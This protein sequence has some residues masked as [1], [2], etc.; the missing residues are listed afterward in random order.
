MLVRTKYAK[1]RLSSGSH[2]KCEGKYRAQRPFSYIQKDKRGNLRNCS[3]LRQFSPI[4]NGRRMHISSPSLTLDKK[5][6]NI[7]GIV[8]HFWEYVSKVRTACPC[9]WPYK[10]Q[11][12]SWVEL[13][14]QKSVPSYHCG[15]LWVP[16]FLKWYLKHCCVVLALSS[17]ELEPH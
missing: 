10:K 15:S 12:Q 14:A 6:H 13:D 3:D 16:C 7:S 5:V 1:T 2:D 8:F 9:R 11:F 17:N 4:W